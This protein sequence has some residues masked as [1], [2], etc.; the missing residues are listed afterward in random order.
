MWRS[1]TPCVY[2]CT[3][4]RR[5]VGGQRSG[6]TGKTMGGRGYFFFSSRRR[7]TRFDCDWSSDVCS[8]DLAPAAETP[9]SRPLSLLKGIACTT[10][11]V[12]RGLTPGSC[13]GLSL[14]DER[15]ASQSTGGGHTARLVHVTPSHQW[16]LG[17]VMVQPSQA[18]PSAVGW[19]RRYAGPHRVRP[20]HGGSGVVT[21]RRRPGAAGGTSTWLP[22]G[23]P[24]EG[25]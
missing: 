25:G 12:V 21:L 16:P 1:P 10:L 2:G 20:R 7:H 6:V 3:G 15:G 22:C 23:P 18:I 4:S 17:V 8:S 13:P 19:A 5:R 14:C 9:G 11:L 24:P